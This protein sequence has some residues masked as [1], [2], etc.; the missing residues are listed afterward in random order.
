M[1]VIKRY[2]NRKLYDTQSKR[3]I[4]LEGIAD[5]IRDGQQV[6][7]LDHE[8]GDD[9]TT[10]IQ[11]QTIFELERRLK[12]RLPGS[13]FTNLIRAGGDRLTHLREAFTPADWKRRIDD[14]IGRRVQTLV[15]RGQV[16]EQDGLT[17]LDNLLAAGEPDPLARMTEEDLRKALTERGVPERAD[18]I[19]LEGRVQEL[20]AELNQLAEH[21]PHH[22]SRKPGRRVHRTR[23]N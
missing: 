22:P 5:L 4:T 18:L 10:L 8:T 16:A 20:A 6:Q 9:I 19:R 7:V 17:L 1:P 2:S 15:D 12:G 21:R 23:R 14:E 3:Y 13:A 11:A